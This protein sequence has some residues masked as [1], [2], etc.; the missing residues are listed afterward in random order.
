MIIRQT[1][2]AAAF[3]G[4]EEPKSTSAWLHLCHVKLD[5][6]KKKY[7][8][9]YFTCCCLIFFLVLMQP[10]FCRN[11]FSGGGEGLKIMLNKIFIR[12]RYFLFFVC[13]NR[14]WISVLL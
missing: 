2:T 5:S 8:A 4:L 1:T 10:L 3:G 11:I 12:V 14:G 13:K 7:L 6:E 9:F